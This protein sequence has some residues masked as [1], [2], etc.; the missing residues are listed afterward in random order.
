MNR[1]IYIT[2]LVT[3]LTIR[4]QAQNSDT[5]VASMKQYAD[6]ELPPLDILLENAQNSSTI[7]YY[8]TLIEQEQ[9]ILKTEQK[10]WLKYLKIDGIYRYGINATQASGDPS[11]TTVLTNDPQGWFNVGASLSIPLNELFDRG[12]RT[13]RQKLKIQ[14]INQQQTAAYEQLKLEIISIYIQA[15]KELALLK[16]KVEEAAI[17]NM[18]YRETENDFINGRISAKELSAQK[19]LQSVAIENYMDSKYQLKNLLFK[20]EILTQ[21]KIIHR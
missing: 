5:L 1:L 4:T 17:A 16:L 10:D 2:I 9:S 3:L 18:Q 14:S 19:A 11:S 15:E 6:M 20:L 21:T 7:E 13:K 8:N 12:E